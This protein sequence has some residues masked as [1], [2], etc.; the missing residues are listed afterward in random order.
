[1]GETAE[2]DGKSSIPHPPPP[3]YMYTSRRKDDPENAFHIHR[4]IYHN[5]TCCKIIKNL[6]EELYITRDA[7]CFSLR[8][9]VSG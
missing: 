5:S 6:K 4:K 8:A 2:H 1:M 3:P 7:E 9:E